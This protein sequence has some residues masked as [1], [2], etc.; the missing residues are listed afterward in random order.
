VI[1]RVAEEF[2]VTVIGAHGRHERTKPGLGP[3]ASRVVEYAAGT[4]LV[5]REMVTERSPR[6]LL[7]VD[8]SLAS[9][10]ALRVLASYFNV[11]SAEITLMHVVETPWTRLGLDRAWFDYPDDYPEVMFDRVDARIGMERE[12]RV[13][14]EAVIDDARRM[15]DHL[16]LS[17]STIVG[18]GNPATEILGEAEAGEYDL[19]VVGATGITDVKHEMVGS[20]STKVAWHAP[21][22]VAVVKYY[23]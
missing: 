18:E 11:T 7:G 20:V 10:Q 5:A 23:E 13:E 14:A 8:G 15:L 12:M 1:L 3:V 16:G 21:C 9:D 22:S 6:I 2:D 19:I 4:V 17:A